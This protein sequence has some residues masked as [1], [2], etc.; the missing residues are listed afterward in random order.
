MEAKII[1]IGQAMILY[2]SINLFTE[3][4]Q[5][6]LTRSIQTFFVWIYPKKGA[7]QSLIYHI[8]NWVKNHPSL[9]LLRRLHYHGQENGKAV[10]ADGEL[11]S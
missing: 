8:I 9:S 7:I 10:A 11:L 6:S 5:A 4:G 2:G 1:Q 3:I